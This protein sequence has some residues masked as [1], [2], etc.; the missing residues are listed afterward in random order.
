MKQH[1]L[2]RYKHYPIIIGIFWALISSLSFANGN[3]RIVGGKDAK[4]SD[5]PFAVVLKENGKLNCGGT[6]IAPE[7]VLTAAHCWDFGANPTEVV[8]GRLDQSTEQGEVI[9]IGEFIKHPGYTPDTEPGDIV[10][11][12]ALIHLKKS[13]TQPTAALV[14]SADM[15]TVESS[16]SLT[17]IGWGLLSRDDPNEALPDILQQVNVEFIPQAICNGPG[18]YDGLVSNTHFCAGLEQGG[19]DSCQGDSGGPILVNVSGAVKQAGIVSWGFGCADEKQPGLY[20]RI[21]NYT[22]WIEDNMKSSSTPDNDKDKDGISDDTDNCIDVANSDQLDD[23]NDKFGNKCDGDLN[24]DGKTSFKDV[25]LFVPAYLTERGDAGYRTDADFDGDGKINR[26]DFNILV[27][28]FG[29]SPGPSGL[30]K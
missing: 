23:D 13:S 14:T 8:L 12:I 24:N 19:K 29:S 11:D 3:T 10:N 21:A 9:E 27:G 15:A 26:S 30:A 20:T 1:K 2:I 28:L 7:W 6:L 22:Q 4:L 5:W 18:W 25:N 16:K 17:V